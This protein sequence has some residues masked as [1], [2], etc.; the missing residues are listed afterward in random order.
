MSGSKTIL[1]GV[2]CA[3]F[4]L[5]EFGQAADYEPGAWRGLKWAFADEGLRDM[6]TAKALGVVF[7]YNPD[8]RT[9][10]RAWEIGVFERV[11][12]ELKELQGETIFMRVNIQTREGIPEDKKL[13]RIWS[14]WCGSRRS[15]KPYVR[16]LYY[17]GKSRRLSRP[18]SDAA[19]FV[20][21]LKSSLKRN[22]RYVAY[23][24]KKAAWEEARK[25]RAAEKKEEK[26]PSADD[27]K[28]EKESRKQEASNGKK[29]DAKEGDKGETKEKAEE[30]RDDEE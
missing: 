29:R 12:E 20:K 2:F 30:E 3:L 21:T 16:V 17:G 8:K 5:T 6:N 11:K 4:P 28:Q 9:E 24:E 25:A 27:D 23:A 10:C 15:G 7:F 18:P 13:N 1:I 14:K 19:D 22:Q 26:D